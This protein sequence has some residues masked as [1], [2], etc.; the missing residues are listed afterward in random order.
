MTKLTIDVQ[1]T[2]S[3][4]TGGIRLFAFSVRQ[5]MIDGNARHCAG[6]TGRFGELYTQYELLRHIMIRHHVI[7]WYIM[8]YDILW[9]IMIYYAMYITCLYSCTHYTRLCNVCRKLYTLNAAFPG[10]FPAISGPFL[11]PSDWRDHPH[12]LSLIFNGNNVRKAIVYYSQ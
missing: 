11:G 6:T 10:V 1:A 9:C 4:S 3:K 8:Y 2:I 7:L 12:L 5:A